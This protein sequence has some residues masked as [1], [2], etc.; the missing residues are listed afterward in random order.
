MTLNYQVFKNF[1]YM[2][3][4][5]QLQTNMGLVAEMMRNAENL[6]IFH[7]YRSRDFFE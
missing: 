5:I 2:W 7:F 4:V 3:V 6:N 1:I